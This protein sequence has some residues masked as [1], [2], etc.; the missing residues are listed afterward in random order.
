MTSSLAVIYKIV[1]TTVCCTQ[2][3]LIGYTQLK[4][5][6]H[7]KDA[8]EYRM[9]QHENSEKKKASWCRCAKKNTFDLK[10]TWRTQ[11]GFYGYFLELKKTMEAMILTHWTLVRGACFLMPTLLPKQE[12]ELQR[13]LSLQRENKL[14]TEWALQLASQ[15]TIPEDFQLTYLHL[16]NLCYNCGGAFHKANK[17]PRNLNKVEIEKNENLIVEKVNKSM[18]TQETRV[19]GL[20]HHKRRNHWYFQSQ[21]YGFPWSQF[22]W[23]YRAKYS[24]ENEENKEV[25]VYE[26]KVMCGGVDQNKQGHE[27][28]TIEF[29][30]L[31]KSEVIYMTYELARNVLLS[32][33]LYTRN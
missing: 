9:H 20:Y 6:L 22:T 33:D 1:F 3:T 8:A 11:S 19:F 29:H 25:T 5:H 28:E 27:K 21:R 18:Y 16:R 14:T 31:N 7:D 26:I 30:A 2:R 4:D 24:Y 32:L 12:E 23:E 10:K 13:L 15:D 17:C